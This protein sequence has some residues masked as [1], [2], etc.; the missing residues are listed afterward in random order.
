M[1]KKM[2]ALSGYSIVAVVLIAALVVLSQIAASPWLN[3][4]AAA[5]AIVAA[6]RFVELLS[7]MAVGLLVAVLTVGLP[8]MLLFA[9]GANSGLSPLSYFEFVD[10]AQAV[11]PTLTAIV[12]LAL[13][14]RNN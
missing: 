8:L 1:N 4:V 14:K 11:L 12:L 5:I 2:R 3:A 9:V 7:I 13:L 10:V 6:R